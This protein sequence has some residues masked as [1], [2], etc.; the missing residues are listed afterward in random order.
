MAALIRYSYADADFRNHIQEGAQKLRELGVDR[1]VE[2]WELHCLG[3]D[4]SKVL[5]A[6]FRPPK[7]VYQE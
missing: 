1:I 2:G 7:K 6:R 5:Q 4:V 3:E